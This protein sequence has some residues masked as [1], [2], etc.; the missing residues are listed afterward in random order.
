M[1]KTEMKH[2][3]RYNERTFALN[4]LQLKSL[5]NIKRVK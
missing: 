4:F 5:K 2:D 3:E 1:A